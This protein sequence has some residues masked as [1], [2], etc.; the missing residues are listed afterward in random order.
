MVTDFMGLGWK[1]QAMVIQSEQHMFNKITAEEISDPG[2]DGYLAGRVLELQTDNTI[3]A[4]AHYVIVE[5]PRIQKEGRIQNVTGEKLKVTY[6]DKPI[7]I[8]QTSQ[9]KLSKS[10]GHEMMHFKI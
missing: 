4:S 5:V 8:R 10:G 3:R 7:K 9:E 6:R 1:D 2:R